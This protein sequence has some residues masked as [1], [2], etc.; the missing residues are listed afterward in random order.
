MSGRGDGPTG[1]GTVR[2]IR[3]DLATAPDDRV[4][5]LRVLR[6][7]WSGRLAALDS[8][9]VV[10]IGIALV[11]SEDA[12]RWF[13]YELIH[14][15]AEALAALD[16]AKLKRLG[17]GMSAW[18]ETDPFGTLLSGVVWRGGGIADADVM[19][20]TK[21]EDRWW[22]RVALVS[23]VALNNRA[24]G[25]KGDP[26]RTLPICTALA[27]DGDDMVVKALSWALRTLIHWDRAAV[28]AFLAEHDEV[29]ASR[30][31]REVRNKLDSGLKYPKR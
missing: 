15:H 6:K 25:G 24:R 20:W 5:T 30:V 4:P 16:L 23:T 7:E 1:A 17:R 26:A 3:A 8:D 31:V 2:E 13:T 21:S 28:E 22:R 29:L 27:P 9:T 14:H 11:D 12:P 19:A 18:D 10:Q